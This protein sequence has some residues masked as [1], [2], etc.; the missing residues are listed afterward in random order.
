[1]K[2]QL[3]TKTAQVPSRKNPGDAGYDLYS[4]EDINLFPGERRLASTG[5]ALSVPE[6]HYGRVAPRSSMAMKGV[7]IGAGVV[8]SSYRGEVKVLLIYSGKEML[9]IKK[10][11]RIAQLLLEKI[12][13]PELEVV[14]KLDETVRGEGG[15]GSTGK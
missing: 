4:D 11:D 2:V 5:V 7:D 14:E 8:D 3:L 13:T 1:M 12:I 15:F 10:G 9:E 6:G